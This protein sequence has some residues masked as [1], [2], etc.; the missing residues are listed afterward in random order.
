MSSIKLPGTPHQV[1]EVIIVVN[2]GT[3]SSVVVIPLILGDHAV[4][5]L[6]SEVLL[7]FKENFVFS[8][9]SADNFGVHVAVVDVP[10]I[11][12]SDLAIAIFVEFEKSL[13]YEGLAF[14]VGSAANSK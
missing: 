13:V 11:C 3:H 9:L 7:K 5:V 10:H 12:G 2:V 1:A 6:V 8:D 4:F 14:L